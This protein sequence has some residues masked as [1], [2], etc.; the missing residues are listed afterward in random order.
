[1][2]KSE[3]V[4]HKRPSPELHPALKFT[5]E[6]KSEGQILFLDMKIMNF[7]GKLSSTWYNNPSDA[8][9]IMNFHAITPKRYKILVVSCFVHRIHRSCS[10]CSNFHTILEKPKKVLENSQ[11][12][13]AFHNPIIEKTIIRLIN[14]EAKECRQRQNSYPAEEDDLHSVQG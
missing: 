14:H 13:P 10:N 8:V 9:L 5:I 2:V 1:M 6:R 12:L 11:Y 7:C 3:T 4:T